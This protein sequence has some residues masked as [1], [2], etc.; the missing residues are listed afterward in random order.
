MVTFAGVDHVAFTVTDLDVSQQFYTELLD[1]VLVMDVGYGRILMHPQSG[2][3]LGLLTHDQAQGDDFTE[4]ATGLDHLGFVAESREELEEWERRFDEHGV[5][6]TPIR[7]ME[8]GFHLN[9]RDPDGIALEFMAPNQLMLAA[10]Q[11]LAAGNTSPEAIA[12]FLDE[13]LSADGDG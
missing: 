13:N 10:Q 11:E 8:F 3:T 1:F 2:F 6:Y 5:T 9:F 7:D 4:L 12:A